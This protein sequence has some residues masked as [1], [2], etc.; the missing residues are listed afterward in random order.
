LSSQLGGKQ[1]VRLLQAA[2]R[3]ESNSWWAKV[4]I[5]TWANGNWVI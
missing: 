3:R 4:T 1:Q 5:S 2:Y